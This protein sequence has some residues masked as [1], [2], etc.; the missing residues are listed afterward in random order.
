MTHYYSDQ[1]VVLAECGIW[2]IYAVFVA[3]LWP[4][5]DNFFRIRTDKLQKLD[6]RASYLHE[7]MITVILLLFILRLRPF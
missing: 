7:R 6:D 1:V 5:I 4:Y 3:A 2:L